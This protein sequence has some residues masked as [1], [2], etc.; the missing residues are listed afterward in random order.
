MEQHKHQFHLLPIL[1]LPRSAIALLLAICAACSPAAVAPQPTP[2]APVNVATALSAAAPTRLPRPTAAASFPTCQPDPAPPALA[3]PFSFPT[4][5][6]ATGTP[7]RPNTL[8]ALAEKRG[9]WI[10][11]V[12]GG[13]EWKD[14]ELAALLTSEFNLLSIGNY[15]KWELIHPER[16]RYDFAPADR[17]VRFAHENNMQ[18]YAHV[19]VWENQL[20]DW[21]RQGNYT[22]Q[23]MMDILCRH[24][25][26][27]V[28]HYR[29]QVLAWDVVNEAFA[30][31][32]SMAPNLWLRTIGPEYIA[33][34]FQWAHE[35]D[36]NALLVYNDFAA[37]GLNAKSQA[38]YALAQGLLDMG[39]PLDGIGLQ[40]HVW[41]NGPPTQAELSANM[42]RLADLGL[43]VHI[44][45]MD[46]RTQYSTSTDPEKLAAQ[47]QIYRQAMEACLAAPNC[48]IF[49]LWGLVD[50]ITWI[51]EV[52]GPDMPLLFD[53]YSRP[54]PAYYAI[55]DALSATPAATATP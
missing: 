54:K 15:M 50:R 21:L 10:G 1:N 49:S 33:M 53:H 6:P 43:Q 42:Q 18:I 51:S 44:T 3:A 22:R 13:D 30:E 46:V 48:N 52:Y 47:A 5:A 2:P 32:G 4:P 17:V 28:G 45:E 26:T 11:S 36:P 25:K 38:I 20:P 19:L 41:L 35:A 34:S 55:M 27:V 23:A 40:M 29:G 12:A 37:D 9:R 7:V 8:R 31:D 14:P 16:E 24:I 39:I